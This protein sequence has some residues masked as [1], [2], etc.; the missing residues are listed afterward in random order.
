ML[1]TQPSR[2]TTTIGKEAQVPA[3]GTSPCAR[4]TT[5]PCSQAPRDLWSRLRT[6]SPRHPAFPRC[7]RTLLQSH[8][9]QNHRARSGLSRINW[10]TDAPSSM[11]PVP[12]WAA[13]PHVLQECGSCL[14]V[15]QKSRFD[16]TLG[17][18]IGTTGAHNERHSASRYSIL[19]F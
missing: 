11:R 15:L 8:C 4:P 10:W 5:T 18:T 12:S 13:G 17:A 14:A 16:R 1:F 2:K 9:Y 19:L 7:H 6:F 3:L